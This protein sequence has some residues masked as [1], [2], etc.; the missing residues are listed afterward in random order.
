MKTLVNTNGHVVATGDVQEAEGGFTL[1][2]TFYPAAELTLL[3]SVPPELLMTWNGSAW[4][5][6]APA[7]LAEVARIAPGLAGEIDAAVAKITARYAPYLEEYKT[8]ETQ[9]RAFAAANFTGTVPQQVAAFATPA[10]LTAQVATLTI[11]GQ[12]DALRTASDLLGVQ[13]MRK[14]EVMRATT[15]AQARAAH[16]DVLAT[17]A[18]IGA[19]IG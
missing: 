9:A 18:A 1:A 12:A 4:V 8:R 16:S 6:D 17:I 15:A 19:Q 14:Y 2:D 7:R 13:R 5:A 3:D 10:G 11:I